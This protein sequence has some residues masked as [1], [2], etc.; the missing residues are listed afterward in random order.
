MA[1]S[2]RILDETAGVPVNSHTVPLGLATFLRRVSNLCCRYLWG[3]NGVAFFTGAGSLIGNRMIFVRSGPR[4]G[5]G[6]LL[7]TLTSWRQERLNRFGPMVQKTVCG[8]FW[9]VEEESMT[10]VCCFFIFFMSVY[11]QSYRLKFINCRV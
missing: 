11:E 7:A 1:H 5:F 9:G 2:G 6:W 3:G 4:A 8:D 10:M